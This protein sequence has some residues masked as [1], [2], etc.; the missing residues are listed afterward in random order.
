M[1]YIDFATDNIN[2]YHIINGHLEVYQEKGQFV[3]PDT[4]KQDFDAVTSDIEH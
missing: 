1:L 3:L 2:I 4:L